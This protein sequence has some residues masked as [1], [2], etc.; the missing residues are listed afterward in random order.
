MPTI[1]SLDFRKTCSRWATEVE[2]YRWTMAFL[3]PFSASKVFLMMCSRDWVSTWTV[4]SSGI[5]SCSMRVRRKLYSVSDAAGKPTSI[6]L[7]P[8][9]HRSLKNSSFSSRSMGIISDWFPSRR[10][11]LHQMGALSMWSF[12]IHLPRGFSGVLG[13]RK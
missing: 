3:H 6:S 11:T 2:L 5:R 1:S 10:S 7:N 9:L 12:S 4:T 13:G 8:I